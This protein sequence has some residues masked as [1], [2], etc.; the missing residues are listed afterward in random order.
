MPSTAIRTLSYDDETATLFVTFIDGD[1]YAYFDVA[2]PVARDFRAARS[3]GGFF[4]RRVRSRYRYQR[5]EDLPSLPLMGRVGPKGS[6]GVEAPPSAEVGASRPPP[7]PR[8]AAHPPH[9]GEGGI[10][11]PSRPSGGP[12]SPPPAAAGR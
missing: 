5:V 6:D 1:V 7:E 12:A 10:T 2:P 4:A 9:K 11:T 8:A 3:K